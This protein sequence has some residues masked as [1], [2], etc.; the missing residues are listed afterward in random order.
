MKIGK[1]LYHVEFFVTV[2]LLYFKNFSHTTKKL[3]F[4]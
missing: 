3:F 4:S 1:K 2:G